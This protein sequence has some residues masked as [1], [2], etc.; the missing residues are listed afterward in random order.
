MAFPE[1]VANVVLADALDRMS[2]RWQVA[3]ELTG[4]FR[5][6][7]DL[8][9]DILVEPSSGTPIVIQNEYASARATLQ[10][11]VVGRLGK[12]L[13]SDGT[14]ISE[15]VGLRS[16]DALKSCRSVE[17]AEHSILNQEFEYALYR[18]LLADSGDDRVSTTTQRTPL[19]S[20]NFF[21]GPITSF[22][23]FLL[24]VGAD[25]DTLQASLVELD[26]GVQESSAILNA[27]VESNAQLKSELAKL[28][29]QTLPDKDMTQ[30]LAIAATVV[31]N[32]MLIQ[33]MLAANYSN[34]LSLAQMKDRGSL[35]LAGLV[36]QW[37]EISKINS[38][39]IY[40]MAV[41]VLEAIQDRCAAAKFIHRLFETAQ[42]LINLGIADTHDLCGVVFQRFMT[43]R[44]HL[45]SFYTRPESA[46]LL[47]HL[48]V[49]DLDWSDSKVYR[50]FKFADYACGTGALIHGVYRRI[51]HLHEF[52][53][54][55]PQELHAHVMQ[56]NITA[57]DI[58]P[59]AVQLTSTLLSSQFPNETYESAR[60]VVPDYGLVDGGKRV[61]L[62]SLELLAKE[63]EFSKG[64]QDLVIMNPPYTRSMSD[65][66]DGAH[67]TWKPFNALGN[68]ADT[69]KRMRARERQLAAKVACYNGYQ[70]MPSA[71]CGVADRMLKDGGTFAFVLP[72]TSLQGVSWRKFRAMLAERY[73]EIMVINISAGKATECAWSADTALAEVLIIATKNGSKDEK[74][75]TS[76]RAALVSLMSRPLNN[77]LAAE[78]AQAI[79]ATTRK[80]PIRAFEDGPYGG[81]PLIVGGEL[82][83]ELL[84]IPVS[85]KSWHTLGIR[86]FSL[87]QFAHQ[88]ALGKLW[89]PR[90]KTPHSARLSIELIKN[91][92]KVGYADNNIAN[93]QTA[94]YQR[95][96]LTDDSNFPMVWKKVSDRQRLLIFNPDQEGRVKNGREDLAFRIWGRRSNSLVAREVSFASQSLISGYALEPVIGGRAWPNVQLDSPAHEKAFVLWGNTTLGLISYWYNSSRQQV[97]RGMVTVTDIGQLPWL[98]VST[99]SPTQLNAAVVLFDELKTKRFEPVGKAC[100]DETRKE[101]D[102]RLL[103]EVLG[104]PQKVLPAIE[105]LRRKWCAEPSVA[106]A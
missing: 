12:T 26:S 75:G 58:V 31:I 27:I 57:A 9:V 21:K 17:Q 81:T 97:K 102:R 103:V 78:Y 18:L 14:V 34:V 90:N 87:A 56:E 3:S 74:L 69:Q 8:R 11:D 43:E 22:A 23:E 47:A 95:I 101:L 94:A 42:N 38:W 79:R 64:S 54:G 59:A 49:P 32:A 88:L 45:A 6:D 33:Q 96:D 68:T 13:V 52:A 35:H 53:G 4:Q 16:P 104:L 28:L 41:R 7:S 2:Q 105:R 93:N 36:Q 86:D 89:F 1:H 40:S 72:M 71:F 63:E 10:D 20:K 84:S 82:V 100:D 76:P 25:G 19:D 92:A 15:V 67:G 77:M 73:N 50:N 29:R 5:E 99:L 55:A 83:G 62:G 60:V 98:D 85:E 48:A 30:G 91:F 70:S 66:I 46:S 37:Q 65:W 80:Q 51:S 39:P 24:N 61:C 106:P 44:K